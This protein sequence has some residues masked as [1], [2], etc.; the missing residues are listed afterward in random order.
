VE[1]EALYSRKREKKKEKELSR[2][3]IYGG[4]AE[5]TLILKKKTP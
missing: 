2:K 3:G 1:V 5:I 4:K